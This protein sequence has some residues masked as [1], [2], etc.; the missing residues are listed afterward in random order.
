SPDRG[1][2]PGP[3]EHPRSSQVFEDLEPVAQQARRQEV[4]PHVLL[5]RA[6]EAA[7]ELGL[8]QDLLDALRALVRRGDQVS[9]L[10][11]VD[12]Q[13][14]PADIASDHWTNLPQRFR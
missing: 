7:A 4:L 10:P 5:T 12:L 13:R 1:W 9:R 8:A 14:D 3:A 2:R 11:V 6:G